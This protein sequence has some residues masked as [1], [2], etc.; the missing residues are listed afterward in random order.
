L[1]KN[2]GDCNFEHI[3]QKSGVATVGTMFVGFGV[4]FLD[5][6]RDGDEDVFVTNGHVLRY[7]N[8]APV[9]QLPLCFE[10]QAGSHF[11]NVASG[12]GDYGHQT[13]VGRGVARGDLD[14]DGDLDVTVSHLDAASAL[15]ENVSENRN[16]WIA[17]RLIGTQTNRDAIGTRVELHTKTG[18]QCR[19]VSSGDSYLSHSDR[20]LFW[21]IPQGELVESLTIEWPNGKKQQ[22]S[23]PGLNRTLVFH[24]PTE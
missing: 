8:N 10:S 11:I 12:T 23:R 22:I 15:L 14:G 5:A 3:S 6:D 24:E 19:Q 2:L 9:M 17:L 1:Y 21:G 16:S 7:P 18:R 20:T 13:H 4:V